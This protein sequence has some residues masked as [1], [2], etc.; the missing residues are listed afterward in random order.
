MWKQRRAQSQ[1][2]LW[3]LG[4]LFGSSALIV[5]FPAYFF[6]SNLGYIC[7]FITR[8]GVRCCIFALRIFTVSLC[9]ACLISSSA[10]HLRRIDIDAGCI[11]VSTFLRLT[12][13]RVLASLACW[14][15]L[16]LRLLLGYSGLGL[17][18]FSFRIWLSA[19][20][21]LFSILAIIVLCIFTAFFAICIPTLSLRLFSLFV[22]WILS[23]L[24]CAL[25]SPCVRIVGTASLSCWGCHLFACGILR[26]I[27]AL[28]FAFRVVVR[29]CCRHN[30][31]RL[32][33]QLKICIVSTLGNWLPICVK[34]NLHIVWLH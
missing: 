21:T 3:V 33:I 20:I 26:L 10:H 5:C 28:I 19:F 9:I 24:A 25:A 18:L 7:T 15:G 23:C 1:S 22:T 2:I 32:G 27:V 17:P 6:G 8:P 14:A 34:L 16:L 29:V 31:R 13:G 30:L 12:R 11:L 4:L